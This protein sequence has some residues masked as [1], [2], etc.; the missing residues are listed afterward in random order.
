MNYIFITKMLFT[1]VHFGYKHYT[2][3]LHYYNITLLQ[4]L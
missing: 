3:P 1:V 2:T 4:H